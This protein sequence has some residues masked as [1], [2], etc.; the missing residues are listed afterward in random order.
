MKKTARTL[1]LTL[2]SLALISV[3]Q[4]AFAHDGHSLG[5]THHWHATDTLG[6]VV[7]AAVLAVAVYFGKK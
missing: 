6:F 7:A 3:A 4:T 5:G 2:Q 1:S